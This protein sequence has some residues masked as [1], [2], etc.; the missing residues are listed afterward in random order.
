MYYGNERIMNLRKQTRHQIG[1]RE[2]DSDD[3]EKKST[4]E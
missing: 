1:T 3:H 4:T 2:L